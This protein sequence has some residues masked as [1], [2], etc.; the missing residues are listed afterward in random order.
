MPGNARS[1]AVLGAGVM[2]AALAR[3]FLAKGHP[4]TVWNRTARR[5]EPLR[6][7]GASV[8]ATAAAAAG[9]SEVVVVCIRDYQATRALLRSR[10]LTAAL[11]GKVLVQLSSGTPEEARKLGAWAR[12][13]GAGYLDGKIIGYP[14]TIGTERATILYAG[15]ADL[16]E[17]TKPLLLSL[18]GSAFHVGERIA[19]A[20]TLDA[21]WLATV[22]AQVMGF[23]YGAAL[24]QSE[25]TPISGLLSMLGEGV[26]A[27]LRPIAE[28]IRTQT[29]RGE[30]MASIAI[31]GAAGGLMARISRENGLDDSLPRLFK[32]VFGRGIAEGYGD[33]EL[34]RLI[35]IMRGKRST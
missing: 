23:L 33:D 16:F 11:S 25:E 28:M 6:A 3:A 10:R 4:V 2:G 34:A 22:Y 14:R 20:A 18:G 29:Y 32:H 1:V 5:C 15:P 12:A 19:A 8:A 24:C 26:A 13:H 7:R 31:H 9:A 21:A 30:G 17:A 35:D 27:G